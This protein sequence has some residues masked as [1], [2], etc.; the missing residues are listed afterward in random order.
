MAKSGYPVIPSGADIN[1]VID[2]LREITRLRDREDV[3]DFN[4]LVNRFVAGR[5]TT[6]IPSSSSDVLA[7]DQEGDITIAADGSA[8]YILVDASGTL[9]WRSVTLASF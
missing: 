8:L 4:N 5:K 1:D 9:A 3:S 2:F 6:R 7:T